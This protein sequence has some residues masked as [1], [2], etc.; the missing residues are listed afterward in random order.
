MLV[1]MG[2]MERERRE[3]MRNVDLLAEQSRPLAE[4]NEDRDRKRKRRASSGEDEREMLESEM[5]ADG[6]GA[7]DGNGQVGAY[8][9]R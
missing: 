3:S 8:A 1:A 9:R 6:E 7:G 5:E 2:E 4:G